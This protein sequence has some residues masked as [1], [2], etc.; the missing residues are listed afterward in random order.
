MLKFNAA[1]LLDFHHWAA[2]GYNTQLPLVG[3]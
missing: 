3:R 2:E 1:G